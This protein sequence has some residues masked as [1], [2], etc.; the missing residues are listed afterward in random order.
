M[1]DAEGRILRWLVLQ[2]DVDE[3]KRKEAELLFRRLG[4]TFPEIY[5]MQVRAII[6]AERRSTS[7]ASPPRRA[8]KR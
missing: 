5:E 1:R 6:E 2:T 3:R 7:L 8:S 4:I